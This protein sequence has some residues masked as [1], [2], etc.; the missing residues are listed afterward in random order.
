MTTSRDQ[1]NLMMEEDISDDEDEEANTAI[2]TQ[3]EKSQSDKSEHN[4]LNHRSNITKTST[5]NKL[6]KEKLNE[7]ENVFVRFGDL[8]KC[9]VCGKTAPSR[10]KS[11]LRIYAEMHVEGL[12]YQCQYCS[13]IC[14]NKYGLKNHIRRR[15]NKR[16]ETIKQ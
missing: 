2:N 10:R 1:D 3:D 5:Q 8:W 6:N 16:D 14:P 15:H 11:N 12:H 13:K 4:T 9:K 7:V